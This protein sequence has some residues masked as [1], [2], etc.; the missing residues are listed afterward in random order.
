MRATVLDTETTGLILNRTVRRG[1]WPEVIE[2][3]SVTFDWDTGEELGEYSTLIRPQG[4][5]GEETT[6]ITGITNDM[7]ASSPSFSGVG[8]RI[9]QVIEGS[10]VVLAHHAS[11]DVEMID[12]EVEKCNA[13][14]IKWPR[15]IC[16]IEQTNA[17]PGKRTGGGYRMNLGDLHENLFGERFEDAHRAEADVRAL[18]RI[19]MKLRAEGYL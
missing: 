12:M 3:A 10:S 17:M 9:R 8:G 4:S 2:F 14:P 19:V 18:L 16:T 1:M 7:V 15:V 5:I 13:A 6:K 11:F